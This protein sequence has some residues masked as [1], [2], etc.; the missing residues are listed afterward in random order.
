MC[1]F[2]RGG[3]TEWHF[4]VGHIYN[5]SGSTDYHIMANDAAIATL[6]ST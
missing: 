3:G 5:R 2:L 4:L 1:I 6:F